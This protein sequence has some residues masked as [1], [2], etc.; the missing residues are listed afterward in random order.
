MAMTADR[1]GQHRPFL[2][3]RPKRM[4]IRPRGKWKLSERRAQ[5][6]AR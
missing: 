6:E 4:L 5:R 2:D 1:I 3:G